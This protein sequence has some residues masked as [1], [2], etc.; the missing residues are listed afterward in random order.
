MPPRL[1]IYSG[2][3]PGPDLYMTWRPPISVFGPAQPLVKNATSAIAAAVRLILRDV[4][5]PLDRHREFHATC[6]AVPIVLE[7]L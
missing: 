5:V 1:R 3:S 4:P 2:G 6:N 7:A